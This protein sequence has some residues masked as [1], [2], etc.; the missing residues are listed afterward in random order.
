MYCCIMCLLFYSIFFCSMVL[1][2]TCVIL[3]AFA[4]QEAD[5]GLKEPKLVVYKDEDLGSLV[6]Y[7]TNT[8][9]DT[10]QSQYAGDTNILENN[11]WYCQEHIFS[12]NF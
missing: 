10:K 2:I 5:E 4:V 9:S 1:L 8:E 6:S 7:S 12:L 3:Y 11:G